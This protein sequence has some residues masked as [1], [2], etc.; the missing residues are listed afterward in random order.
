[1]SSEA[2]ELRRRNAWILNHS[3]ENVAMRRIRF[4]LTAIAVAAVL[5]S[6]AI[7]QTSV[8][9]PATKTAPAAAAP[10]LSEPSTAT[11]VEKWT[12][13][14]WEAAKKELAKDKEKWADCREQSRQQ[15]LEGRKRW[16]FLYKCMTS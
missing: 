10:N 7:A 4:C 2:P 14:Q 8:P 5:S 3:K 13:K 1:L 16:S 9:P 15:K 12:A 6:G 11:Q